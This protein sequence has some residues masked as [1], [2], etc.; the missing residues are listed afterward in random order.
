VSICFFDFETAG[1]QPEHPEIQLAAIAVAPDWTEVETFERKILF[2]E[3]KAEPE[4]LRMNHYDHETWAREA[5]AERDVVTD[6][7]MFLKRHSSLEMVS[8]RTGNPYL[9]ARLAG[10]NAATFD[11]PRLRAMF[12]RHNAFLPAHPISMDTL[13]RAIWYLHE[14]QIA[15]DSLRLESLCKHFGVDLPD[16]HDA[17]ADA[18]A[19]AQIARAMCFQ[20]SGAHVSPVGAP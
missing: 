14:R 10:H 12:G 11:G 18:R 20:S 13:Q 16:S 4:A 6:F 1:L 8:K 17:L 19:A 15:I 9:V 7:S 2:D 5:K 3:E